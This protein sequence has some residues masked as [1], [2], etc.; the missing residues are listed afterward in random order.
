VNLPLLLFAAIL[1]SNI[2]LIYFLGM[3]PF[4]ALSRKLDVALGMGMAVTFVTTLTAVANWLINAYVLLPFGLLYLQFLVFIITIATLVQIVEIFLD[5]YAPALYLSFGI[6]LPLI[7]V[8][9]AILG[10]SLFMVLRSYTLAQTVVYSFGSGIG[11]M[12]AI[13]LLGGL[14]KRLVYSRPPLAFGEPGIAAILAGIMALAFLGFT[15]VA[16]V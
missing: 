13:V 6:F 15:G 4:L 5:R 12:L 1:T 8:N 3:C 2:A 16:D 10:V 7:T 11:W 9:C 14:R